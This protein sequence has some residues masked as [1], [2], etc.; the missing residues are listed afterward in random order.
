MRV[1]ASVGSITMV[2]SPLGLQRKNVSNRRDDY[3]ISH[4]K[5]CGLPGRVMLGFVFQP[6]CKKLYD[7]TVVEV[8][9]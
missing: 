2:F 5:Y 9:V 3:S 1:V 7:T 4:M 8:P 6:R